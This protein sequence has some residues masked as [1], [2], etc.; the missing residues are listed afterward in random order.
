MYLDFGGA[1]AAI[2]LVLAVYQLRRSTWDV[3]LQL[4]PF[5]QRYLFLILSIVGAMLTLIGVA[6]HRFQPCWQPAWL[7]AAF[8]YQVLAYLSFAAAP[9]SLLILATVQKGLFTERNAARFYGVLGWH[10][11]ATDECLAVL[12]VLLHNFT[13]LAQLASASTSLQAH[14]VLDTGRE[15]RWARVDSRRR[16]AR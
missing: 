2:G 16:R 10:L 12:D 6:L 1:L 8:P 11:A 13:A 5:W 4:R 3:V 15:Y 14:P 7:F 9:A